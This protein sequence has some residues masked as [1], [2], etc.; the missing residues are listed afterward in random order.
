MTTTTISKENRLIDPHGGVLVDLISGPAKAKGLDVEAR[1][2]KKWVLTPRQLCDIEQLL[3]GAFSPLDGFMGRADYEG[4]RDQMRL[5]DGTLWPMPIV[6]DLPESVATKLSVGDRLALMHPE[7]V[8]VAVLNVGDVWMPDRAEEAVK[9]FGTDDEFHPGVDVL[10]NQTGEFYVGG[11]LEGV[12]ASQHHTYS[13]LRHT[14]AQ[15]RALFEEKGWSRI[16]AFQ[17]R[18]P[19]HR[20]HVE[21]TRRAAEQVSANLLIHPV[22]GLTKPGDVEYH[23]RVRCYRAVLDG[24][25]EDSATLSLLQ[26]AMRMGGPREAVWHA[27]VRKNY[28]CT[29]FIVGRD[30]AGPG[31]DR[32]GNPF[33]GPYDAQYLV[34]EHRDELGIE[35]VTFQEVVYDGTRDLYVTRDELD[36]DSKVMNLSGTELRER[37]ESGAEIPEWFS[38]PSVIRE[39]R[40]SYPTM[41]ERG[42][43][44]YISGSSSTAN[45]ALGNAVAEKLLEDGSRPVTVLDDPQLSLETINLVAKEASRNGGA[46]IS[47]SPDTGDEGSRGS[48]VVADGTG[49]FLSVRRGDSEGT[50]GEMS[51]VI[52]SDNSPG[53][54]ADSV[55][56]RLVSIGL[57]S[58]TT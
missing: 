1:S 27:I 39:L 50:D 33:Y 12:R 10:L 43:N 22:V 15:L 13:E 5:V 53:E 48:K 2:L 58:K 6:L 4:V 18:N 35:V 52:G 31:N 8:L 49:V 7:G 32:D 57:I 19:M 28:G 21:L 11:S 16:V 41:R 55:M 51:V 30:H 36:E 37:L 17:T 23:T 34:E 14:P 9:V 24:Y 45:S 47:V 40:K 44:V 54:G 56:R 25:S 20:A 29:H 3:T 46:V 42:F 38:F 26:L